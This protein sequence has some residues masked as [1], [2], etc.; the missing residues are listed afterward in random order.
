MGRYMGEELR[1][2]DESFWRWWPF[3]VGGLCGPLLGNFLHR[4]LPLHYSVGLA[5]F[6]AWLVALW[7]FNRISP[8]ANWSIPRWIVVSV[9]AGAIGGFLAFLF[10]Y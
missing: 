10:P 4:W 3:F 5:M 6:F 7:V 1:K 2:P 9:G 8:L